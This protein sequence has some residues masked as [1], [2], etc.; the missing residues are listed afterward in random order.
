MFAEW[1]YIWVALIIAILVLVLAVVLIRK[2]REDS[3]KNVLLFSFPEE[4]I[5]YPCME[6]DYATLKIKDLVEIQPL[7]LVCRSQAYCAFLFEKF[8][9]DRRI[10]VYLNFEPRR[11]NLYVCSIYFRVWVDPPRT[12]VDRDRYFL[13]GIAIPDLIGWPK[14]GQVKQAIYGITF[15]IEGRNVELFK[16]QFADK[17]C[18]HF[19]LAAQDMPGYMMVI[20]NGMEF[21][22]CSEYSEEETGIF[23]KRVFSLPKK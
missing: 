10:E 7:L 20:P 13:H 12:L 4:N 5:F 14:S 6:M 9:K 16:K 22:A 11:N 3:K 18:L 8:Y 17:G 21:P 19:G 2:K 15:Q 1:S 23:L